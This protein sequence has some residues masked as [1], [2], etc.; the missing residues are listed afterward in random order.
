MLRNTTD[1][2]S[3]ETWWFWY[4]NSWARFEFWK[5]SKI[6]VVLV[7]SWTRSA[8]IRRS[9]LWILVILRDTGQSSP[10]FSVPSQ[11]LPNIWIFTLKIFEVLSLSRFWSDRVWVFLASL[12]ARNSVNTCFNKING[13]LR[14]VLAWNIECTLHFQCFFDLFTFR[15]LALNT[16]QILL[17]VP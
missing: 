3:T 15:P 14:L 7:H 16:H 10:C 1:W 2:E 8:V 11:R 4:F 9:F 6:L 13:W 12:F 17:N 5:F